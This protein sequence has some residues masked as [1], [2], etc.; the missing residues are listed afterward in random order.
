MLPNS[1]NKKRPS[2][3]SSAGSQE[4]SIELVKIIEDKEDDE[5]FDI[6]NSQLDK[7]LKQDEGMRLKNIIASFAIYAFF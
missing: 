7:L 4:L 2:S 6:N 3:A 1:P 5:H